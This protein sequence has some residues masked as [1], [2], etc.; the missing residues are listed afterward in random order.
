[1]ILFCAKQKEV[2]DSGLICLLH[3]FNSKK[4]NSILILF[5]G[6]KGDLF[7]SVFVF[8]ISFTKWHVPLQFLSVSTFSHKERVII[9]LFN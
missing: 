7:S 5:D 6:V 4:S 3:L 8:L 9:D 1:M 2:S